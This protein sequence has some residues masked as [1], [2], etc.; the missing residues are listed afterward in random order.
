M[1]R[2][3]LAIVV[4][5]TLP[6]KGWGIFTGND[7]YDLA[8]LNSEKKINV[9]YFTHLLAYRPFWLPAPGEPLPRAFFRNSEGSIDTKE[10]YIRREAGFRAILS[11]GTY[12]GYQLRQRDD[13]EEH[14]LLQLLDGQA[15]LG[16]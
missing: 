14:F 16:R 13:F 8:D 3:M 15:R 10:L 4:L 12:L 11:T 7:Q 2:A 5:L 1:N 6:I 9:E